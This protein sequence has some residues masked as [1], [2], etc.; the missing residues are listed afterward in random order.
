MCSVTVQHLQIDFDVK[1]LWIPPLI[2]KSNG[3]IKV[4]VTRK[5][6]LEVVWKKAGKIVQKEV[7]RD[8]PEK[9]KR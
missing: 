1:N 6:N 9:Q 3:Y 4:T 5:R 8:D 2:N 7:N